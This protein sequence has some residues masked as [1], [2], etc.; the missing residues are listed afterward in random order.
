MPRSVFIDRHSRTDRHDFGSRIIRTIHDAIPADAKT[1]QTFQLAFEG[2]AAVGIVEDICEGVAHFPLHMGVH[3][4]DKTPHG[5]WSLEGSS[6]HAELACK[7]FVERLPLL[8]ARQSPNA[9]ANLL[10][11]LS[12]RQNRNGLVPAVVFLFTDVWVFGA[13]GTAAA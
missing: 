11:E 1:P 4:P 2:V 8:R 12:I 5:G 7:E 6:W 3:V 9:V 10:Q 13:S